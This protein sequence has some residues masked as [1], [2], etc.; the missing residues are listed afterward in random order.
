[1]APILEVE[2]EELRHILRRS[3]DP[4][5]VERYAKRKPDIPEFRKMVDAYTVSALLHGR[6][7]EFVAMNS[8]PQWQAVH[9]PLRY[10]VLPSSEGKLGKEFGTKVEFYLSNIILGGAFS[11]IRYKDRIAAWVDSVSI[12]SGAVRAGDIALQEKNGQQE[13]IDDETALKLAVRIAKRLEIRTNSK[14]V[15]N[16][17][18][19][20]I[21]LGVGVLTSFFLVGWDSL[22]AS[23]ATYSV[24]KM[25]NFGE[26]IAQTAYRRESHLRDLAASGPGRIEQIWRR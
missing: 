11:E 3:C 24:S 18:D 6:Y 21:A 15:E 12:V 25:K 17:L 22:A 20:S 10:P 4:K 5:V 14:L 13:D 1:M 2:E 16:A 19:A 7:H 23:L 8:Q 9:H 26:L